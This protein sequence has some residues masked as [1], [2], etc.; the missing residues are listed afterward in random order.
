MSELDGGD[1]TLRSHE[2]RDRGPGLGLTVVPE[3][4]VLGRDAAARLDRGRLG[5]DHAR[6]ADGVG[7]EMDQVPFIH[8]TVR[9]GILAHR[10]DEDAVSALDAA[11]F[12][13]GEEDSHVGDDITSAAML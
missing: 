10:R 1:S 2:A 9:A 4:G 12:E 6:A 13:R 7:A 3:S 11:Y 5:D 8:Q